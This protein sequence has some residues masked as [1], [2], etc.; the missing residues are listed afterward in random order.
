MSLKDKFSSQENADIILTYS[1]KHL[2]EQGY[3]KEVNKKD[4]DFFEIFNTIAS[5]VFK[6][7]YKNLID[8]P[9]DD[10]LVIINKIVISEIVKY[11]LKKH[12]KTV[13]FEDNPEKQEKQ[14]KVITI[15][16]KEEKFKI[17]I[18]SDKFKLSSPIENVTEI[19][20]IG[21]KM[22]NKEYII[23]DKNNE[24]VIAKGDIEYKIKIEPGNYNKDTLIY[25]ISS[26]LKIKTNTEFI[27]YIDN[28]TDKV[29]LST[30]KIDNA[31]LKVSSFR[32]IMTKLK[33]KEEM[34]DATLKFNI[35]KEKSTILGVLGFNNN[36]EVC[37]EGKSVYTSDN[38]IKLLREDKINFN[39]SIKCEED[40]VQFKYNTDIILTITNESVFYN[41]NYKQEFTNSINIG[42]VNLNFDKYNH[43]G[44][45]FYLLLEITQKTTT[46]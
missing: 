32:E 37:L 1:I 46:I 19:N 41:I 20:I 7:E 6:H 44:Y 14:E 45:P 17:V 3:N 24:L 16:E 13:R 11:T 27:C 34:D 18:E 26:M 43:N 5:S 15:K 31:T 21:L 28:I 2:T 23:N 8:K 29:I 22:Y 40:E 35:I 39:M 42:T 36:D 9:I 33:N 25:E 4:K 10:A 30:Q 38:P 12:H